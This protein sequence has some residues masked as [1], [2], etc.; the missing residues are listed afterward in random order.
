[1]AKWLDNLKEVIVRLAGGNGEKSEYSIGEEASP[2]ELRAHF[3]KFGVAVESDRERQL[4]QSLEN[5]RTNQAKRVSIQQSVEQ[6][7]KSKRVESE[8]GREIGDD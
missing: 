8:K 7:R 2:E 1:M 6:T 5:N 4:K 3:E